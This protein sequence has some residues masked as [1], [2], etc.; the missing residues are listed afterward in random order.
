MWEPCNLYCKLCSCRLEPST[1]YVHSM[2]CIPSTTLDINTARS[3]VS[4][5]WN[6]L[7]CSSALHIPLTFHS[8]YVTI[9]EETNHAVDIP[10]WYFN[11]CMCIQYFPWLL[12]NSLFHLSRD[13][14]RCD[15]CWCTGKRTAAAWESWCWTCCSLCWWVYALA[16]LVL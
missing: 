7:V 9:I 13:P 3:Y 5:I 2:R 14:K 16:L 11:S 8:H 15:A 4:L 10:F 1:N 6:W 12:A